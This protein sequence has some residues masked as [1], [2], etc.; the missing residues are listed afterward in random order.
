MTG[1]QVLLLVV[2]FF[3]PDVQAAATGSWQKDSAGGHLSV[4][5]QPMNSGVLRAPPSVPEHAVATRIYW[6]I[7]LLSS[8][9]AELNIQLCY[10]GGCEKLPGLSGQLTPASRWPANDAYYFVYTVNTTG[11]LRP[12][13]RV[14]QNT[15]TMNYKMK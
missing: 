13:V 12:P 9:A 6:N 11:Q 5:R 7:S 15:L 1:K 2:S 3:C 14:I 4:G 8:P 10:S